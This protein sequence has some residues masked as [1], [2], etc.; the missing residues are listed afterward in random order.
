ML[1][2]FMLE[3]SHIA[4]LGLDWNGVRVIVKYSTVK[5]STFM[6]CHVMSC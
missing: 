1:C 6:S 2:Y 4:L 5:V 3:V